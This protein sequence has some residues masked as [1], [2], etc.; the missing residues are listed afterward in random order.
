M[1]V[2]VNNQHKQIKGYRDLTQDEISHMNACKQM[3]IDVGKLCDSVENIEGI[4]KRWL[5][6]AK[7]DLQKGFMSLIR[8]IARPE[9]F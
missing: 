8:S 1:E 9:T 4:D 5:A 6:I 2:M 3:A 7:T